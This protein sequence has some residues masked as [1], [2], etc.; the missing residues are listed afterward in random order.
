MGKKWL[1][2]TQIVLVSDNSQTIS[3]IQKISEQVVCLSTEID[4][5]EAVKN[6]S[7]GIFLFDCNS[8]EL[9]VVS[10]LRKLK[11]TMQTKD[12]RSIVLLPEKNINYDILKYAN[13][14][15][16]RPIDEELFKATLNS[17]MQL[18]ETFRVLSKNN[19][20]LAKSLYQFR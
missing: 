7:A 6:E 1:G 12:M 11:L 20:D 19:N 14:Y 17:N 3:E 18:K 9:D 15:I 16:I 8:K 10:L 5:E 2:M 4:V 13:S